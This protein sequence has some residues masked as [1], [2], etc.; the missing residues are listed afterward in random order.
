VEYFF[1]KRLVS[2]YFHGTYFGLNLS[3]SAQAENEEE[4]TAAKQLFYFQI[5]LLE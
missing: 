2:P 4:K 5:S 1:G 3:K